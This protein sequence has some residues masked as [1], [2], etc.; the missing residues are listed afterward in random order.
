VPPRLVQGVTGATKMVRGTLAT[1]FINAFT[2]PRYRHRVKSFLFIVA[3]MLAV[4]AA[5]NQ[6]EI[7]ISIF[8]GAMHVIRGLKSSVAG[9]I[10]S[11]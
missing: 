7:T 10:F 8:H 3:A 9:S 1:S 5:L 11:S 6:S 4:D 2:A